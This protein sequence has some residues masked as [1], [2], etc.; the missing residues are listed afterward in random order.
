MPGTL[1]L[2]PQDGGIEIGPLNASCL[3]RSKTLD[4]T[5]IDYGHTW[6]VALTIGV[7]GIVPLGRGA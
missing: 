6:L 2:V 1:R 4:L 3:S 7:V 5:D